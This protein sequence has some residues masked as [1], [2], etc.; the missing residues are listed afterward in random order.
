AL[1]IEENAKKIRA[2]VEKL[3]RHISSYDSFLQKLGSSMST[4]VNHYN[5][6]YKE[7]KKI[8]KDVVKITDGESEIEPLKIDKPKG[9]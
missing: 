8:D 4:S 1:D 7:F 3:G 6:A 5:N 2:N 9:E